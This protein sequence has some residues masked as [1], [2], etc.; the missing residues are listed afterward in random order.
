VTAVRLLL[1]WTAI[2]AVGFALNVDSDP[3]RSVGV[4]SLL[5]LA[6]AWWLGRR[7]E[8]VRLLAATPSTTRVCLLV[9]LAALVTAQLAGRN[10]LTFPL[11]RWDMYS[12]RSA[13]D[14]WYVDLTGIGADGRE[15]PLDVVRTFPR[16]QPERHDGPP[17]ARRPHGRRIRCVGG[18]TPRDD[19]RRHDP[20]ARGTMVGE[21]SGRRAAR[22]SRLARHHSD[23]A[24]S[25]RRLGRPR[26]APRGVTSVMR[27][28]IHADAS[29]WTLS[30]VR[31][32]IFGMCLGDVVR[33]PVS[34]LVG[35][36]LEYVTAVGPLALLPDVARGLLYTEPA[37]Q[38]LKIVVAALL[39]ACVVGARPFR[40]IALTTCVL[41][42]MLHALLR[43]VGHVNH[44]ELPMLYGAWLL[45]LFPAAPPATMMA[46]LTLVFCLTYAFTGA[47]RLA[48]SAP[49]IF[50]DGSVMRLIVEPGAEARRTGGAPR[51]GAAR[52]AAR[53]GGPVGGVRVG[54]DRRAAL[55]ARARP[56]VVPTAVDRQHARLPRLRVGRHADPLRPQP[57]PDAAP[58]ARLGAVVAS[59]GAVSFSNDRDVDDPRDR[60]GGHGRSYRPLER[61]G[62][63]SFRLHPGRS[64]RG[65]R[66]I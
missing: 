49:G 11:V 32:W 58:D 41:L 2:T 1:A 50:V 19:V 16:A 60:D 3:A 55:A 39:A 9:V 7:P 15:R 59:A 31:V 21:A 5:Y 54:D 6:I 40:P 65:N 44:G 61:R 33:E 24:V 4:Q 36:P 22:R 48:I 66:S 35:M 12:T 47:Y 18:R 45:A 52:V 10:T 29:G 34:D 27:K 56:A 26:A 25:W 14:P 51:S 13:N 20:R 62:G 38:G 64:T 57:G 43:S 37:L 8:I 28:L 53:A 30:V 63:A 46:V 17:R 42:T 23:G